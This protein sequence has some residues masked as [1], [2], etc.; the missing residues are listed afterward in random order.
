MR[1]GCCLRRQTFF[2]EI[3]RNFGKPYAIDFILAGSPFNTSGMDPFLFFE[4]VT[5]T[6]S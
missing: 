5:G 3:L 4:E 6:H 1:E 2:L